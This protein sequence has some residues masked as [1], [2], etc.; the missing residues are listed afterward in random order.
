MEDAKKNSVLVTDDEN[1][2]IIALTHILS[3]EYTVYAAKNGQNA[4]AAA[5]KYQ[6]DIILLDI[7]MPEMDGY[8]VISALKSSESTR[9]I[10]VIFISG[11]SNA[12]DEEKGLSLGASD[13]IS[14]PFSPAIVKLR[15]QNQ[16]KI[17]NQTHLIIEKETA[18]KS[19]RARSEF[20]SRMSHEMRTP[21][22]AIMGMAALAKMTSDTDKRDDMLDKIN[23]ASGHLM[24]LIDDVLDMSDIEDNVFRLS[25]SPFNFAGMMKGILEK[26]GPDLKA[27][28]QSLTAEID[29]SIP[30]A[31]IGDERRLSQVILNLLSNA[32][33]FTGE[34]GS[35]RVNAFNRGIEGETL[36]MQVEVIDNGIGISKDQLEKLFIPFEQ[37]D[38][39][40]DRKFGG[41]GLGLSISNH[42]IGL[43][44]GEIKAESEIGN[45]SKFS[46]TIK[47]QL[48]APEAKD[49]RPTLLKG[50]TALLVD[51][52][53]INR[54][55]VMA[56]LE[57]TGIQIQCA[58]DG[59]GALDL[60]TSTPGKFDIIFMDI[61]MPKMDGVE[62]AKRIRAFEKEQSVKN[63]LEFAKQT[64][65]LSERPKGVPIIAMTA[66][67]LAS[68]IDTYLAA[69]MN[70]HIGKPLDFDK[71]LGIL[72]KYLK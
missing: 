68:D 69:G 28:Q 15:V 1:S 10:P 27:K 46:F 18:E 35:L 59:C 54:E 4:I 48:K 62:A 70:E 20:L 66:N 72:N 61:N 32:V 24:K 52:V 19:S 34:K 36:T 41:A 43:M 29:P 31:L 38:G 13:Y 50:K 56:M 6:P 60:Y 37:A 53:E 16:I 5:E 11:L 21:M 30:D 39:G 57:N 9:N 33:K 63:A 71:L 17:I 45:G 2:N 49:D 40:I 64:Q 22:N 3:P 12:D 42:I 8:D 51:D 65:R 55:I 23:G 14:K 7:V 26:T 58:D 44:G 67:V 25:C 47:V